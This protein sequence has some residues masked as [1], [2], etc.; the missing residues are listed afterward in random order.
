LYESKTT[1]QHI[2]LQH[3]INSRKEHPGEGK[4]NNGDCHIQGA[5]EG[6]YICSLSSQSAK[7]KE[8]HKRQGCKS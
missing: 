8:E 7:N 2:A 4:E 3:Q 1:N 5:Q 6:K